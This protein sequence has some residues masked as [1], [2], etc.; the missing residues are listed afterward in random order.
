MF[1]RNVER[2]DSFSF[3]QPVCLRGRGATMFD[4]MVCSK[5]SHSKFTTGPGGSP[6]L[7]WVNI[8]LPSEPH[9]THTL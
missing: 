5:S 6:L 8:G 4:L 7:S 3:C 2:M 1:F 9:S